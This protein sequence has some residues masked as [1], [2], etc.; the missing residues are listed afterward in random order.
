[1]VG[2][3]LRRFLQSLPAQPTH[4][5]CLAKVFHN[6]HSF[7]RTSVY[8]IK[9]QHHVNDEITTAKSVENTIYY[10]GTAFG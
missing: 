5:V 2:N 3:K 6:Y 1:M 10:L 4:A 7:Q 9:L 8:I